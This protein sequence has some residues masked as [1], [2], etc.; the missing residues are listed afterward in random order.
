MNTRRRSKK[1]TSTY[2]NALSAPSLAVAIDL[3]QKSAQAA[4]TEQFTNSASSSPQTN[5]RGQPTSLKIAAAGESSEPPRKKARRASKKAA[6]KFSNTS[7]TQT[8]ST[9]P[10]VVPELPMGHSAEPSTTPSSTT[11]ETDKPVHSNYPTDFPVSEELTE[12]LPD[13]ASRRLELNGFIS[14][15]KSPATTLWSLV[16]ATPVS[17]LPASTAPLI[18]TSK[19]AQTDIPV[20]PKPLASLS[21]PDEPSE[22][23]RMTTRRMSKKTG[24]VSRK[25]LHAPTIQSGSIIDPEL[26]EIEYMRKSTRPSLTPDV[27]SP[28]A[29]AG[30]ATPPTRHKTNTVSNMPHCATSDSDSPLNELSNTPELDMGALK[31]QREEDDDEIDWLRPKNPIFYG[32]DFQPRKQAAS[33]DSPSGTNSPA[34][35]SRGGGGG[36][37]KRGGKPGN[38][39]GGRGRARGGGRAGRG[40]GDSPD[41]KAATDPEAKALLASMK[42]RQQDLKKFFSHVGSYQIDT[43]EGMSTKDISQLQRKP[44]AH[45][46]LAEHEALLESLDQSRKGAEDQIQGK[47]RLAEEVALR[48]YEA[49]KRILEER[50]KRIGKLPGSCNISFLT[51]F[52]SRG[53]NRAHQRRRG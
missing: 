18:T 46:K 26:I 4:S 24:S 49:E 36:A 35:K 11:L 23:S 37:R 47:Y 13:T 5:T 30:P 40:G 9:L 52:S 31:R 17:T 3:D 32:A 6:S 45:K 33:N 27:G 7:Q 8:S 48:E 16:L 51:F 10:V 21:P 2:S 12:P 14:R 19:I 20:L 38:G 34:R 15:H 44:N 1:T 25:T 22:T 41:R 43:L 50:C 53:A 28:A 29:S 39:R 42:A